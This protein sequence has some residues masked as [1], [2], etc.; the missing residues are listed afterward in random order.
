MP[1]CLPEDNLSVREG[2][3]SE[4]ISKSDKRPETA[5]PEEAPRNREAGNDSTPSNVP[6]SN[7]RRKRA[8]RGH[9][10]ATRHGVLARYPLETLEKLGEDTR[11]LRRLERRFRQALR[12]VGEIALLL[13]DK[14]WNSYIHLILA[15]R[16]EANLVVPRVTSG[17]PGVALPQLRELTVPTLFIPDG[18]EVGSISQALPADLIHELALLQRYESH[19]SRELYRALHLLLIM[20]EGGEDGLTQL[21]HNNISIQ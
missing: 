17:D 20:R 9:L 13:F 1:S 15:A 16:F 7:K 11:K 8:D 6:G 2:A 12:P 19:H 5:P 10:H 3:N 4:K 18:S 21:L 14:F